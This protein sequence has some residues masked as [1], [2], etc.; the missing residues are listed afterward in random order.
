M[1]L[2]AERVQAVGSSSD[3]L[4]GD[5]MNIMNG[6]SILPSKESLIRHFQV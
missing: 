5:H 1:I 6:L 2:H 3:W 4:E